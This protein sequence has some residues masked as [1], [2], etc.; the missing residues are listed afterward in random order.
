MNQSKQ[1][2][3]NWLLVLAVF[4]LAFAPLIL[5][6]NAD[7]GGADDK[8][9]TAIS[10]IQP[11]YQPWFQSIFE[12]PS[13]EVASLLFSAQAAIGAGV[14]GYAI[15]LYKGRSQQQKHEE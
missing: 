6:R 10:Q 2:F 15:G 9:K 4:A 12:P 1:D 8:A 7:F 14:I 13:G 11:A 5:V 3:N